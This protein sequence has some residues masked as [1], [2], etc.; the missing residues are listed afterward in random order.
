MRVEVCENNVWTEQHACE[1]PSD[2]C[3]DGDTRTI[4]CGEDNAG[5]Q[6]QS[7]QDGAWTDVGECVLEDEPCTDGD[8]R[9]GSCGVHGNGIQPEVCENEAW[10]PTGDCVDSDACIQGDDSNPRCAAAII[11]GAEIQLPATFWQ[12]KTR[13]AQ[14]PPALERIDASQLQVTDLAGQPVVF[15]IETAEN[16]NQTLTWS[17]IEGEKGQKYEIVRGEYPFTIVDDQDEVIAHGMLPIRGT[18]KH[19]RTFVFKGLSLDVENDGDSAREVTLSDNYGDPV[20]PIHVANGEDFVRRDYIIPSNTH[21][22]Y[23]VPATE[24]GLLGEHRPV[25]SPTDAQ[26]YVTIAATP[27]IIVAY[28]VTK[29]AEFGA[30]IKRNSR[31]FSRFDGYSVIHDTDASTAAYDR[32]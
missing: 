5:D 31:H 16:G 8:T 1:I 14:S 28:D 17:H 10:L 20:E 15:E 21:Y 18:S 9:E 22:R 7:C 4:E 3:T 23:D 29:G 30:W 24:S 19:E 25:L 6:A 26:R 32:S 12:T 2:D 11:E 13:D 27:A